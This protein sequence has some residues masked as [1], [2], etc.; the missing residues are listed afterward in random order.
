M[1]RRRAEKVDAN[2]ADIVAALRDIPF[3]GVEVGHDDILVGW[4]GKSYWFE[5]KSP[6]V[7]SKKTGRVIDSEIT[8]SEWDRY[9]NW[10]GHYKIVWSL[11][12]ILE[13]LGIKGA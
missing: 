8:D 10:P 2:Q 3:L 4:M 12:Q 13:E 1:A 6:D 5:I 9:N 11:D 7:V